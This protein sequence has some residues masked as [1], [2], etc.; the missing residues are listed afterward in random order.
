MEAQPAAMSRK[1]AF[2]L[3]IAIYAVFVLTFLYAIGFLENFAVPKSIDSGAPSPLAQSLLLDFALL[4]VFALQHSIMARQGF[5]RW[6]TRVVPPALERS[7]YVL[8]SS[9]ALLLLFWQWRP[10]PAELWK[11]DLPAGR[12]A[13]QGLFLAGWIIALIGTLLVSH[14]ELFGLRQVYL[15]LRREKPAAAEF[16]TPGLYRYVRHPI[17]FG[18]LIAIWSTPSM[19]VGRLLFAASSTAYLL[20]GICFEERDL[21]KFH[22]EAYRRYQ[23]EVPMLIPL[24]PKRP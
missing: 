20:I 3:G 19:T 12:F 1:L 9:L 8:F 14:V 18:F 10:L 2:T 7:T 17:Y 23:H 16:R 4:S 11:V 21:L 24:P 13:L 22:G 6:W 5:K 15:N